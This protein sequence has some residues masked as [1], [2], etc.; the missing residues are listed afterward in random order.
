M[1]TLRLHR[2][3]L[4]LFLSSLLLTQTPLYAEETQNEVGQRKNALYESSP[5]L[6]RVYTPMGNGSGF[7]HKDQKGR[8]GI[9][10]NNHVIGD[11]TEVWVF[12]D[13]IKKLYKVPV[14]SR[15]PALDVALLQVPTPIPREVESAQLGSSRSVKVGDEVYAIGHP[16]NEKVVTDGSVIADIAPLIGSPGDL[17]NMLR[18][19]LL[20]VQTPAYP[21]NS[22]GPLVSFGEDK[23]PQ[24]I[25]MNRIVTTVSVMTLAITIDSVKKIMNRLWSEQTVEHAHLLMLIEDPH[26]FNPFELEQ[27][28]KLPY[29][30]IEGEGVLVSYIAPVSAAYKSGIRPGD[31]ITG[32]LFQGNKIPFNNARSLNEQ[33]FFNFRQGMTIT[34]ITK[35]GT[36]VFER[37]IVL[38][39]LRLPSTPPTQ[40]SGGN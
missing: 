17:V 16:F 23:Q 29:T 22:G 8:W 1:R 9:Y 13:P 34:L 38:D 27:L 26:L 4:F 31:L 35:R 36:Q 12:F 11:A 19:T 14:L 6:V 18:F 33:I 3:F 5:Y 40:P 10:T 20:P 15:D 39:T 30:P 37:E 21:G 32:F 28:T 7:L 2:R 25:G 24:V